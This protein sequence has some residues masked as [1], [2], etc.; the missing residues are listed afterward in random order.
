MIELMGGKKRFEEHLD[1][2]FTMHLEDKYIE[3]NEDITR[4]GIMGNYVHGNEPSHHVPYLY[5]YTSSPWK[6]QERVHAIANK[7]Y[8]NETNGL[9][10]N[11]DAGQMS[12][13][14]VF[15][16]LGIYPTCPGSVNY[17]LGSPLVNVAFVKLENGKTIQIK[18]SKLNDKNIYVKSVKWNSKEIGLQ[19]S[20]LDLVQGGVLEFEMTSKPKKLKK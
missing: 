10:G 5:N 20:H 6:T 17:D 3:K 13:W 9:C 11:D 15:S 4:D 12:A 16:A 8:T 2:L 19:I 14:Y 7:F 18:A 1:S